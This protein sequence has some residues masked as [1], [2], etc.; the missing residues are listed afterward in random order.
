MEIAREIVHAPYYRN[1]ARVTKMELETIIVSH[2]IEIVKLLSV[3]RA[4]AFRK[5]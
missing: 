5:Y 3:L 4:R 1:F 2:I